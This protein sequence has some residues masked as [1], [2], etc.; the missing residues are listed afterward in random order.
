MNKKTCFKCKKEKLLSEFYKH[1]QMGDGHLNKCK[2]CTKK[3]SSSIYDTK[4]SD[5]VFLEKERTRGRDKYRRL[6][7]G[8]GKANKKA[9]KNWVAKFPEKRAAQIKAYCN[10]ETPEGKENHHWSYLEEHW[11]DIIFMTKKDHKKS[12]RFLVYD[13]ERRMYRQFD[14]NELL[15]T[16]EKHEKF[17]KYCIK[18]KPD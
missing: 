9:D 10:L 14:T 8:T 1:P 6:Y 3:D 17:I 13:S 12:H 16:K 11:L 2:D 4:K 7:T 15:D 18:N 5:V